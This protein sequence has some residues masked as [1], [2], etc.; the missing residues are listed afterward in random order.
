MAGKAK[1]VEHLKKFSNFK[2]ANVDVCD[3]DRLKKHF[4]GVDIVFH[5]AASKKTV[6][7]KDPRMDL[8]VNAKGTFNLLELSRDKGVKKLGEDSGPGHSSKG[9]GLLK[10]RLIR[11]GKTGRKL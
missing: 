9:A 10:M 3:F 8:D 11:T 5:N 6:S 2:E 7:L 4:R 1:N